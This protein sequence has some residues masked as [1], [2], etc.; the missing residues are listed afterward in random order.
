MKAAPLLALIGIMIPTLVQAQTDSAKPELFNQRVADSNPLRT[1]QARELDEY[2]KTIAADHRRFE[3]LFQPDYSSVEAFEKSAEPLRAAF[4]ESIGYPPPGKRPDQAASYKKIGEDSLG[5]YYRAMFPIL[6]HVHSE[7]IL[8]VPKSAKAKTP[9]IISMHGGGGSPEVALFNGGANYHDMVRGAVKRGFI[10]YA[11]QH[12]F[13]ADGYPPDIRRQIDDRMRLIGTSITA[14]EIAKITYAIDELIQRPDVDASRI[15]MVG[16]SYGGYYAQVTP[17]VDPR[18]KVSVS[19]CYF[20]VQEGR[21]AKEELSVPSDFRFMNR[22]TL[23]ND[24][25][26]VALICP[27]AHQI[28]AGS[29]DN[30]SH[31]EMG[32]QI[33]PQAAAFYEQLKLSDRFEHVIFEGGHEFNDKA[34]WAFVEKYL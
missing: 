25:D 15:G 9:L 8:I 21:Y 2:I 13:K 4:C 1:E 17:A 34:A 31:R 28:Q 14:V 29:R 10:V 32:K 12:L 3:Q 7:G 33:S 27:R 30:A 5:V 22:M 18:I 11:P 23:F 16:L 26:L 19:S 20:G 24:A 6:P